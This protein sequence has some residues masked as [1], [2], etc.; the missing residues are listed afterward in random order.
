M[1]YLRNISKY[2]VKSN[3]ILIISKLF[4]I[5]WTLTDKHNRLVLLLKFKIFKLYFR[6]KQH[7]NDRI[8]KNI[9]K[10]IFAVHALKKNVH[11]KV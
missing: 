4:Q 10:H 11:I 3:V 1:K 5:I 7:I 9:K 8:N 6:K 2:V